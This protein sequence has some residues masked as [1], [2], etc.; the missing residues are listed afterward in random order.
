MSG[1]V[2]RVASTLSQHLGLPQERREICISEQADNAGLS[3]PDMRS[4][5]LLSM[6]AQLLDEIAIVTMQAQH[7]LSILK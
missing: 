1:D 3:A 6:L 2:E 7:P 5:R 4:W